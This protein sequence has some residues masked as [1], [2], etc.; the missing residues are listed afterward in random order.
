MSSRTPCRRAR[1]PSYKPD[2]L[3]FDMTQWFID[4]P[5]GRGLNYGWVLTASDSVEVIG[6]SSPSLSPRVLFEKYL[7]H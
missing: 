3:L 2:R 6:D 7:N 5:R 1:T 4:Y